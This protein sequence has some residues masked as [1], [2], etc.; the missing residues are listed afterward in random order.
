MADVLQLRPTA[1]PRRAADPRAG[2]AAVI[3]IDR[4]RRRR[5]DLLALAPFTAAARAE[6]DHASPGPRAPP[7]P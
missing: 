5:A 3:P 2:L 1:V 6:I 7:E 4:A